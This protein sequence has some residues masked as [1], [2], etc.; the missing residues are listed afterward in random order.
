MDASLRFFTGDVSQA[1]VQSETTTRHPIF[2][3]PPVALKLPARSLLRLERPLYGLPEAELHWYR[4]YHEHQIEKLSLKSATHDP[5]FLYT[6]DGMS[7]NKKSCA[8][9]RGFTRLQT[10]DTASAGNDCFMTQESVMA[11]R[12]DCKPTSVLKDGSS[13]KLNGAN[14]GLQN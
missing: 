5:C 2:V 1:Y 12:L 14:I 13:I 4:T 7:Q 10:D 3:R 11:K 8:N 6:M 9:S